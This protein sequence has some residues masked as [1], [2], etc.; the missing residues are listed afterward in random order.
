MEEHGGNEKKTQEHTLSAH[1]RLKQTVGQENLLPVITLSVGW[2]SQCLLAPS[3]HNTTD[4]VTSTPTQRTHHF[5]LQSNDLTHQFRMCVCTSKCEFS[6]F[7]CNMEPVVPELVFTLGVIS[8]FDFTTL[9][10]QKRRQ[11]YI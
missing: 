10:H 7:L 6:L 4:Q 1:S 11:H 9:K 5:S 2:L 8:S 3:A